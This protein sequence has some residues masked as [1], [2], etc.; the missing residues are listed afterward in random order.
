MK[1]AIL[2]NYSANNDGSRKK[3]AHI[4]QRVLK[5]LPK[6]TIAI[7]YEIPF[8]LNDCITRLIR[9]GVTFFISAGGDGSLN[10]LLNTILKITGKNSKNYC[11]GAIGLGSS[12]DFL[13]PF[14]ETIDGIP[15][16]IK[17]DF[18]NPVDV[19]KVTYL[20]EKNVLK[21]R[22]FIINASLGI[23]A[24]ANL[25]F[26][27]GDAF[28]RFMKSRFTGLT[29][30]YTA[31]KTLIRFKNKEVQLKD[32]TGIHPVKLTNISLTKSP[33][34]SGSFHYDQ[35]PEK[36]CGKLGFHCSSAMTKMEIIKTLYN[37]S[38]GKFPESDHRTTS[39]VDWIEVFSKEF[40]ALETDGEVQF[41]KN[42]RFINIP[43]ALCLAS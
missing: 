6:N 3:W 42:S 43:K 16:K 25:L 31:L 41:G 27:R 8:N 15:V 35:A 2:I 40:L 21:S 5:I 4:G 11:L 7:P 17:A 19:G 23:T 12:N 28:I 10:H 1:T 14:S 32:S 18:K 30:L 26:N 13:K 29:I 20:N 24:D 33:Y 9:K 34:V 36:D 37:L 39:F 22:Y 38:N